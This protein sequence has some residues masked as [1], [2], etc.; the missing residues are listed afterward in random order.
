MSKSPGFKPW[1]S[2]ALRTAGE[3]SALSV[4]T[5]SALILAPLGFEPS[6]VRVLDVSWVKA[7]LLLLGEKQA[8]CFCLVPDTSSFFSFI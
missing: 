3:I 8:I 7:R 6:E 1:F 4:D 5:D 2:N